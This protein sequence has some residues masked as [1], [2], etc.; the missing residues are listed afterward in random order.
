MDRVVQLTRGAGDLFM[1]TVSPPCPDHEPQ[2][3]QNYKDA[4][5]CAGGIR[6][7]RG[8]PIHDQAQEKS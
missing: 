8:W 3:F 1:V 6:I 4:R 2:L 5:G 7:T